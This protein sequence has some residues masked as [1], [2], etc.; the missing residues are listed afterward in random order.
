LSVEIAD[1]TNKNGVKAVKHYQP[2]HFFIC[3]LC[4]PVTDT[5]TFTL[6]QAQIKEWL[7]VSKE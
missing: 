2:S 4:D 7:F 5:D 6:A 1:E 3:A